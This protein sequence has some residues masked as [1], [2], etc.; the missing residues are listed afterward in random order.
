MANNP[1]D[2]DLVGCNDYDSDCKSC[3]NW[4][5][6]KEVTN[7]EWSGNDVE[8]SWTVSEDNRKAFSCYGIRVN[9]ISGNWHAC[10][11]NIRMW[12]ISG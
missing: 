1:L 6:L 10:L 12:K 8:K 5:A 3:N 11:Q 9:R 2:F 7:E 4:S